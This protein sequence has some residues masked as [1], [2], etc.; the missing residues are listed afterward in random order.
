MQFFINFFFFFLPLHTFRQPTNWCEH[1]SPIL[2]IYLNADSSGR[3]CQTIIT[4]FNTHSWYSSL[5]N[6][7]CPWK[8]WQSIEEERLLCH[9]VN[10]E[11]E[12]HKATCHQA[13]KRSSGLTKDWPRASVLLFV[14]NTLT[15]AVKLSNPLPLPSS[16]NNGTLHLAVLSDINKHGHKAI[17]ETCEG[18]HAT[19]CSQRGEQTNKQQRKSGRVGTHRYRREHATQT[20]RGWEE[21]ETDRFL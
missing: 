20:P 19:A 3:V 7:Y 11:T 2:L 21:S 17:P 10:R 15:R 14:S 12:C 13:V 1:L 4:H 18:C 8:S 6:M 9:P 5:W 16:V